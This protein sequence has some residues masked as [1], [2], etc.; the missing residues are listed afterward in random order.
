M[1]RYIN[2]IIIPFILSTIFSSCFKDDVVLTKESFE[3]TRPLN[4]ALPVFRS[5][6]NAKEL[7]DLIQDTSVSDALIETND[8]GLL[9]INYSM[10][11]DY[12]W[13][14]VINIDKVSYYNEFLI[15]VAKSTNAFYVYDSI[16]LNVAANQ[17]FDT[18]VFKTFKLNLEIPAV[19]GVNANYTVTFTSITKEINGIVD[20]VKFNGNTSTTLSENQNLAGYT[21]RFVH[22]ASR[23]E[24][25]LEYRIDMETPT[26]TGDVP[27]NNLKVSI[28]LQDISPDYLSGFF[29]TVYP[30][31]QEFEFDF[32]FFEAFDISELVSFKG[33]ELLLE[34]ENYFGVPVDVQLND[35]YM[36]KSSSGEVLE[37][38]F[39]NDN[40]ISLD[41]ADFQVPIV[42]KQEEFKIDD[43]NSNIDEAISFFPDQVKFEAV[44][45]TNPEGEQSINFISQNNKFEGSMGIFFPFWFK[46]NLYNRIDT[47]P[48]GNLMESLK[49]EDDELDPV[50]YIDSINFEITFTNAFP[51]NLDLQIYPVTENGS[52]IDSLWTEPETLLKGAVVDANGKVD[53]TQL[54]PYD[55]N[56]RLAQEDIR[57][58]RDSDVKA[59]LVNVFV[60]TKNASSEEPVFVQLHDFNYIKMKFKVDIK[61]DNE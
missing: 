58:Y 2:L 39:L 22:N 43:S 8:D 30:L 34:L 55:F 42:P 61:S 54:E 32:K 46:T 5:T 57:F 51:F 27:D 6:F 53:T 11:F 23:T 31:N 60:S 48:I 21:A 52:V 26:P 33:I 17:R 9:Y 50:D 16:T 35:M 38:T 40:T 19:S 28:E 56:I 41:G 10:P 3:Y 1:K 14:D 47:I 59:F 7:L 29:G 20:T 12:E 13:D 44:V 45:K 15:P 36:V 37:V 4:A 24:S 18:M 25:S 49:F